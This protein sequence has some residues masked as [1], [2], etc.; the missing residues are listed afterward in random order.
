MPVIRVCEPLLAGNEADYVLDC[1]SSNW[2]SS[3]GRYVDEFEQEFARYCGV[4]QGITTTSGTT[5]LHLALAAAGLG[6]GDEVIIPTF[7]MIACAFSVLHTGSRPVLIDADRETWNLD[8]SA[9]EAH[10]SER[11]RAIMPVHVYGHPCEMDRVLELAQAHDLRVIEDAAEAH[12][13][14]YRGRRTGGLG[15]LGCFSFYAN[16]IIT[17]GEG[18]MVVTDDEPLAASCRSLKNLAYA[19]GLQFV[20]TD[21]GFNYR[22]TN[23]QA[24]IGLAQLERIDDLITR[25]RRNARLYRER[26]R[27]VPGITLPVERRGVRNVY[28]MFGIVVEDEFGVRRDELCARLRQVGIETKP[29]FVPMHRQPALVSLGG[30]VDDKRFPV[31]DELSRRGLYLPSGSGLTEQQIDRVCSAIIDV[32]NQS[33]RS[34]AGAVRSVGS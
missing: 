7:T 26:L 1:V 3:Q 22:M 10:I 15:D 34:A 32:R 24:A 23:I 29:F 17:T 21:V 12:G 2:I 25:R 33:L 9:A 18:G 30:L 20:H 6:P 4:S 11:T 5:A 28:W 8:V 14:E 13:A 27:D 19:P 31:A 16:K